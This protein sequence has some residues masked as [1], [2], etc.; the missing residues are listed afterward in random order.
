MRYDAST[1]NCMKQALKFKSEGQ[2]E[3]GHCLEY[4]LDNPNSG[5]WKMLDVVPESLP[6]QGQE[7]GAKDGSTG[8]APTPHGRGQKRPHEGDQTDVKDA[9]PL[10]LCLVCK[11]RHSP[12]CPMPEGFR[13]ELRAKEKANRRAKGRGKSDKANPSKKDGEGEK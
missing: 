8:E 5:L 1:E 2:G 12:F 7:K 4:Y 3:I 9:P 6:D 11:K 13:K 10:K